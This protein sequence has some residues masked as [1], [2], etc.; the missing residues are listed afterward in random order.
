VI[1]TLYTT[2]QT[3]IAYAILAGVIVTS[4]R[5]SEIW[6]KITFTENC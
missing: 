1:V 5:E 3:T 2:Y 6:V 4:A